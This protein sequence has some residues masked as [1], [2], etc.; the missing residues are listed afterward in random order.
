MKAAFTITINNI[1]EPPTDIT[2]TNTSINQSGGANAE[3]GTLGTTD[4]DNADSFSYTL[5]SGDGDTHNTSFNIS[6]SMIRATD[7]RALAAAPTMYVCVR[8]TAAI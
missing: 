7:A 8:R 5:V 2:L 3:V 4:V 6:G 1:N